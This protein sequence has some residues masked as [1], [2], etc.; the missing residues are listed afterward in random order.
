MVSPSR[1]VA[2]WPVH[3]F[4]AQALAQANA[5]PPVAGTPAWQALADTDPLKL[6]AVA[7]A[8]EHHV[9][10]VETAQDQ[11]AEAS[12]AI[13]ESADWPAVARE[14]NQLSNARRTGIRIERRAS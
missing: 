11:Q 12:K 5:V 9:L 6:L 8:G 3:E 1:M 2:W 4:I 7:V 13:A 10:R 14:I